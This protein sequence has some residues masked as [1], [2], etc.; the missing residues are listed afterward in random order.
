MVDAV[1]YVWEKIKTI[2]ETASKLN[3]YILNKA[4]STENNTTI[5]SLNSSIA[6]E[7]STM[8][9]SITCATYENFMNAISSS[10]ETRKICLLGS[11]ANLSPLPIEF[12]LI[13][14]QVQ[15]VKLRRV[16]MEINKFPWN[17]I[18]TQEGLKQRMEKEREE[19]LRKEQENEEKKQVEAKKTFNNVIKQLENEINENGNPVK[20]LETYFMR[21]WNKWI[22]TYQNEEP[23]QKN[24]RKLNNQDQELKLNQRDMLTMELKPKK[25]EM[26]EEDDELRNYLTALKSKW[27][28]DV[29][30]W[31]EI[32]QIEQPLVVVKFDLSVQTN[33]A[34]VLRILRKINTRRKISLIDVTFVTNPIN[35][36]QILMKH[37]KL[38]TE[39]VHNSLICI[40]MNKISN[41]RMNW[42]ENEQRETFRQPKMWKLILETKSVLN[43]LENEHGL[44]ETL[45][46]LM[47]HA[48]NQQNRELTT[49]EMENT[50]NAGK[51]RKA[52]EN[53]YNQRS[54]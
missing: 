47:E 24:T 7:F 11:L 30:N 49:K 42:T 19:E 12:Y 15:K 53:Y 35:V 51:Y 17:K 18:E 48:V 41:I 13:L 43:E 25:P 28:A 46:E 23:N 32:L 38:N 37:P 29:M 45:Q 44:K 14:K 9:S 8:V 26:T 3:G 4:K 2:H 6:S 40:W 21:Q 54:P 36:N 34:H 52:E 39:I 10:T 27:K 33:E 31:R 5:L 20:F 22:K 16:A 1:R 50:Q